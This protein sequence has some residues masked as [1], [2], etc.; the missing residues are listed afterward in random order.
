M[1]EAQTR[2]QAHEIN[3][4]LKKISLNPHVGELRRLNSRTKIFEK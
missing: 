3:R 2:S 1:T 4:A